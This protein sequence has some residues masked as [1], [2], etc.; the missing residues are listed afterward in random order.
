MLSFLHVIGNYF[1]QPLFQIVSTLQGV[2][3]IFNRL[4]ISI[5]NRCYRDGIFR[6]F[7]GCQKKWFPIVF[8]QNS[9]FFFS[10][11]GVEVAKHPPENCDFWPKVIIF[12]KNSPNIGRFSQLFLLPEITFIS[13][14]DQLQLSKDQ[15]YTRKVNLQPSKG[16]LYVAYLPASC[17]L[18]LNT[19]IFKALCLIKINTYNFSVG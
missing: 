10:F 17:L 1:L 9:A 12:G 13:C 11:W 19:A 16:A 7:F 5:V 4:R 8:T 15:L 6:S 2:F 3:W 14:K 18:C